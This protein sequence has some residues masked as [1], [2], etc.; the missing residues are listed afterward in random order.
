MT[1]TT[2]KLS[3]A[4]QTFFSC[5]C[6]DEDPGRNL[7]NFKTTLSNNEFSTEVSTQ[8]YKVI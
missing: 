4:L 7:Q 1:K 8:I 5:K 3:S 6:L 2:M